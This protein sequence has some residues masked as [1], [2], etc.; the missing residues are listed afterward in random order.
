MYEVKRR[1]WAPNDG[2]P[3]KGGRKA[4]PDTTDTDYFVREVARSGMSE[5]S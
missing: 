5:L 4:D 3:V 2:L 1:I